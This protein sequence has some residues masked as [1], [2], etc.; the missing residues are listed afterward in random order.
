MYSDVI[1][2]PLSWDELDVLLLMKVPNLYI[3]KNDELSSETIIAAAKQSPNPLQ[4]KSC[5]NNLEEH[6]QMWY[7]D[8]INP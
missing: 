6:K 5:E 3:E 8:L 1:T 7:I 2:C 4:R